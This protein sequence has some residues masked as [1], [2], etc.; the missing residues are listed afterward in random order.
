MK[1]EDALKGGVA[2]HELVRALA[3]IPDKQIEA[4][5]K[6]F[7]PNGSEKDKLSHE[8]AKAVRKFKKEIITITLIC[9]QKKKSPVTE[10]HSV[11]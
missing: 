4:A 2:L 9:C 5:I 11:S 10:L 6:H 8:T 3:K 7:D 1:N